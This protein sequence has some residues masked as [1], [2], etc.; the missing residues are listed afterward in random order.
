MIHIISKIGCSSALTCRG[1]CHC[2]RRRRRCRGHWN[3]CLK[4]WTVANSVPCRG[5]GRHEAGCSLSCFR[6]SRQTG[7]R[8]VRLS[9]CVQLGI[10]YINDYSYGF[11][12]VALA[13]QSQ[14]LPAAPSAAQRTSAKLPRFTFVTA[15]EAQRKT[16]CRFQWTSMC[17]SCFSHFLSW[18]ANH[19]HYNSD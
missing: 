17:W 1:W 16:R 6:P 8:S 14:G 19:G 12:A 13:R 3:P 18:S 15:Q 10:L 2:G 4:M 5:T 7:M 9:L 11:L